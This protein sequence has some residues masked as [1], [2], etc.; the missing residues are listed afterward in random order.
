MEMLGELR[1]FGIETSIDDF[2]TGYSSLAYLRDLPIAEV[3]IDRSFI[4]EI[5]G[6][7]GD[8]TI[9]RSIV[10]LAHNLGLGVL[11]EGVEDAAVLSVL[12]DLG[13]DRV[14]GFAI[15][16]PMPASQLLERVLGERVLDHRAYGDP[17]LRDTAT[18]A[19]AS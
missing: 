18:T 5:A 14:Q 9:V 6:E 16:H 15:G 1:V 4:R 2:G 3:K 17:A 7:P 11:A 10:D 13:C 12:R 8:V 19:A